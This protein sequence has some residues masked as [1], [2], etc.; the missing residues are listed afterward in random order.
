[1]ERTPSTEQAGPDPEDMLPEYDFD[2]AKA[3][4]NRFA[5]AVATRQDHRPMTLRDARSSDAAVVAAL[6]IQ[7]G[8]PMRPEEAEARLAALQATDDNAV[9]VAESEDGVVIG[10]IHVFGQLLLETGAF[11]EIAGLVVDEA[12]RGRGTGAALVEAAA[13]W[14]ARRGYGTLR[15]RSNVVRERAHA[16]YERLGFAR[17]KTQAVFVRPLG[18]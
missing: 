14:A 9:L 3:H 15:V 17:S 8:Y 16:F 10:W 12:W 6:S 11:A 2:Y 13:E 1:M 5:G 7:L 4:P 18:E